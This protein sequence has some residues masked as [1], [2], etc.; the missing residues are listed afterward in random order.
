M[1]SASYVTTRAVDVCG[2]SCRPTRPETDISFHQN[3]NVNSL[4]PSQKP[5]T[6]HLVVAAHL[7]N[8]EDRERCG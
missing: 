6:I 4:T 3:V 2:C 5:L 7:Q 1:C 8:E